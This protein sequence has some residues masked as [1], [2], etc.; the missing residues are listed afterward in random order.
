[1]SPLHIGWIESHNVPENSGAMAAVELCV[2]GQMLVQL[3]CN[4]MIFIPELRHTR[5]RDSRSHPAIGTCPICWQYRL[6]D[7]KHIEM[8][9]SIPLQ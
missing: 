8:I 1:M 5:I 7:H 2:G 4:Q 3:F 9:G 6:P